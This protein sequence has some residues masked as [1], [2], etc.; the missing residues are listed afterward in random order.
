MKLGYMAIG[1]YGTKLHNLKHPRKDILE[2]MGKT[3]ASKMYIDD[4]DGNAKHVGYIVGGEWFT[5]YEI[6]EWNG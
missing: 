5:V 6:H 1:S 2:R 3:H 4:K